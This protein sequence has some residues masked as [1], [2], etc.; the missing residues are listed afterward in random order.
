[1]VDENAP[2]RRLTYGYLLIHTGSFI[3]S[4]CRHSPPQPRLTTCDGEG[5]NRSAYWVPAIYDAFGEDNVAYIPEC[6]LDD[7]LECGV[8]NLGD[9]ARSVVKA[10]GSG[11]IMLEA[12]D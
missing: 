12:Q 4:A 1:M 3:S 2:L 11:V 7:V 5:L 10:K 9:G 8:G 6:D